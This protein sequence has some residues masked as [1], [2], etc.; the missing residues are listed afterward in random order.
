MPENQRRTVDAVE[1]MMYTTPFEGL[2]QYK[3]PYSRELEGKAFDLVFDDGYGMNIAFPTRDKIQYT[4]NGEPARMDICHCMK[5]ED[6]VYL[7]FAEKKNVSP[8]SAI[9]L[10]LDMGTGLVT[11]NFAQQGA[12]ASFPGLVTR[13]VRFG[14]IQ[15]G[16]RPAPADRHYFTDE[17]NGKKIEWT[18]NPF[19]KIIHCYL[20]RNEYYFALNEDMRA[21]RAAAR[22]DEPQ[23]DEPI[24]VIEPSI[25]IHIRDNLYLFSWIEENGGSGTEGLIVANKDRAHDVGCFF[26]LNPEGN[27][28]AYMFSAYGQWITDRLP[29]EDVA[30]RLISEG[31]KSNK[32][33]VA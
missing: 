8:R 17:M 25:F 27:P 6:D 26:G 30:A 3:A 2:S 9:I 7:V 10:V 1:N 12:V 11:G 29:E 24:V 19:F 18:Y 16:E 20:N 4:E 32:P 33:P 23:P 14:Y 22:P 15:N 31:K 28:E 5:A 13:T 21:R